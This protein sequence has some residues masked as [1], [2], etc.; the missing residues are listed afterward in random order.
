MFHIIML[1]FV[2]FISIGETRIE[3]YSIRFSFLLV[4]YVRR[5]ENLVNKD[6]SIHERDAALF[7][8]GMCALG[9]KPKFDDW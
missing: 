1:S 6:D 4:L 3:A 9:A 5:S 7:G 2:T 8:R